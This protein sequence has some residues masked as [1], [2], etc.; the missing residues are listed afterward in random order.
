MPVSHHI[1]LCFQAKKRF[2][3]AITVI[4]WEQ[5]RDNLESTLFR[6]H[7][8]NDGRREVM[9]PHTLDTAVF[10]PRYSLLKKARGENHLVLSEQKTTVKRSSAHS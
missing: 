7:A 10:D 4:V 9:S 3:S 6:G 2:E 1:L 5:H 8:K